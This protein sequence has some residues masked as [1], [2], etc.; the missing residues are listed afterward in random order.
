MVKIKR[1]SA[2]SRAP[3]A[4]FQILHSRKVLSFVLQIKCLVESCS[5]LCV[6][7]MASYKYKHTKTNVILLVAGSLTVGFDRRLDVGFGR[8]R[9][10][11]VDLC[12]VLAQFVVATAR[13]KYLL[14]IFFLVD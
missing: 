5:N 14:L 11:F 7:L 13:Q 8:L 9:V 1:T 6:K 10:Q 2:A 12:Q 3:G 4:I